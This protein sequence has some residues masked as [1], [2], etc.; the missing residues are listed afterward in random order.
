MKVKLK[1]GKMSFALF[2]HKFYVPG[3]EIEMV[4]SVG[5]PFKECESLTKRKY[6]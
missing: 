2:I 6:A 4:C 3:T 1:K 5:F